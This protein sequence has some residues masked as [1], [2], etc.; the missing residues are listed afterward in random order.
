MDHNNQRDVM[1]DGV[2]H[3]STSYSDTA[4]TAT[5]PHICIGPLLT[6]GCTKVCRFVVLSDV[7][8][9]GLTILNTRAPLL[10]LLRILYC[11]SPISDGTMPPFRQKQCGSLIVYFMDSKF[12][13]FRDLTPSDSVRDNARTSLFPTPARTPHTNLVRAITISGHMEAEL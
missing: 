9:I 12:F 8:T 4:A 5:S 11:D 1:C 13:N 6:D 7:T 2:I 3:H 10:R